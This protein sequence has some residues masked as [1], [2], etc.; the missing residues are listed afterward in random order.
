VSCPVS[1]K[2]CYEEVVWILQHGMPGPKED[3]EKF[4]EAIIKIQKAV[5]E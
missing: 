5:N 4:A 2:V 3:M 1:E